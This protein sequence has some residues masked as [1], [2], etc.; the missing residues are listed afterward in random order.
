VNNAEMDAQHR[1]WIEICNRLDHVMLNGKT[2]EITTETFQAMQAMLEYA[3]YHFREEEEY[4]SQINFPD[5]VAHKRLHTEFDD[6]LYQYQRK[7]LKGELILTSEI[8]SLVKNWFEDHILI[9]D[10]KYASFSQS[11]ITN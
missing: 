6:Q 10:Q 8:I 7:V 4:M 9:E 1:K 11:H 5:V 3:G 2:S